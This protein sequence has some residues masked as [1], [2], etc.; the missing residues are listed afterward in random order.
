MQGNKTNDAD[1]VLH[2][3]NAVYLPNDGNFLAALNHHQIDNNLVIEGSQSFRLI[4]IQLEL[5][6]FL[7]ALITDQNQ[8]KKVE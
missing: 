8:D 1:F 5:F 7:L 2:H 6:K 4:N 3:K